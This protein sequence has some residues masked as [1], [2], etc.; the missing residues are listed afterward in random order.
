MI[1]PERLQAAKDYMRVD[2]PEDDALITAL[3]CAADEYLLDAGVRR[4]YNPQRYDLIAWDM[5]LRAYEN[6][7]G[8]N[9]APMSVMARYML[10]QLKFSAIGRSENDE[11]DGGRTAPADNNL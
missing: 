9:N 3:L 2:F 5:T 11:T 6:R 1:T 7:G 4:E 10:N 8:E